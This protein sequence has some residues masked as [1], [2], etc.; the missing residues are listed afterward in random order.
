M[1]GVAPTLGLTLPQKQ[2]VTGIQL[3]V[4]LG[5]VDH[6]KVRFGQFRVRA[7]F[8]NKCVG[9]ALVWADVTTEAKSDVDST[10]GP[11]RTCGS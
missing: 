5:L 8:G 4:L 7:I 9:F 2:K 11:F 6:N 3:M 10:N 1:R